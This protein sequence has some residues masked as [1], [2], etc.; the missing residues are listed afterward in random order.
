MRF[1][2]DEFIEVGAEPVGFTP[3][4]IDNP[5]G[6]RAT[7]ALVQVKDGIVHYAFLSEPDAARSLTCGAGG[8]FEIDGY[9]NLAQVKFVSLTGSISKLYITYGN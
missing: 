9:D 6:S 2:A 7:R 8:S 3:A 5:G 4:R 1:F